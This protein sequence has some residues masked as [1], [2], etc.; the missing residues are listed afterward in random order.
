MDYFWPGTKV[1]WVVTEMV[2]FLI[3]QTF[4]AFGLFIVILSS[5]FG[6]SAD[7]PG[8][9]ICESI[10]FSSRLNFCLVFVEYIWSLANTDAACVL[11]IA[12]QAW[13]AVLSM[14][15]LGFILSKLTLF[16]DHLPRL[17]EFSPVALYKIFLVSSMCMRRRR[18]HKIFWSATVRDTDFLE[19]KR[20]NVQR[21][22]NRKSGG[23]TVSGATM[24]TTTMETMNGEDGIVL[25][26]VR[27]GGLSAN[28]NDLRGDERNVAGEQEGI[29]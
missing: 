29:V 2:W 25:R 14:D 26:A 24:G 18:G 21:T 6:N 22:K 3:L 4:W 10:E 9:V 15:T 7:V 12:C 1:S 13:R 23:S 5:I 19:W 20:P 8:Y 16:Y 17:I 11:D 27:T 28:G